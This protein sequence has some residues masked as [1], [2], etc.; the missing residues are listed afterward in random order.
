MPAQH[1][2][3]IGIIMGKMCYCGKIDWDFI[4]P[5]MLAS[6]LMYEVRL[7]FPSVLM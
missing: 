3:P 5:A 6:G 7:V 2:H 1:V 4:L